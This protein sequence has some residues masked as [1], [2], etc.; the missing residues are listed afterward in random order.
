MRQNETGTKSTRAAL[1]SAKKALQAWLQ[2][3]KIVSTIDDENKNIDID[4]SWICGATTVSSKKNK[5]EE[6]LIRA[7]AT[8][9]AR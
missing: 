4:E 9:L 3:T 7:Q 2:V 8:G 5:I 6:L 1:E